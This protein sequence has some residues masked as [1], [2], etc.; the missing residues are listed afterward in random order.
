MQIAVI[1]DLLVSKIKYSQRGRDINVLTCRSVC[2]FVVK[3][4]V[5]LP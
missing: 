5:E 3:S 2:V 1:L 4:R